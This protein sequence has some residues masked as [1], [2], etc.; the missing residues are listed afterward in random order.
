MCVSP[1]W[2]PRPAELHLADH[3]VHVWR[4]FLA[5][6]YVQA[7]HLDA[8]LSDDER[9][10][11][12]RFLSP[13]ERDRFISARGILRSLLGQYLQCP[14]AAVQ[15]TYETAGK[16]RLRTLDRDPAIRFNVTHS[17]DL[18]AYAFTRNREV[19]VDVEAVRSDG[20]LDELAERFFSPY[21][22][23][24]LRSLP[25]EVHNEAIVLC[26]TRKEAYVKARGSALGILLDSF[27]V[28]L[29]PGK[30]ERLVSD[31]SHRWMLR[32]FFPADGYVGA[33]VVEGWDSVLHLLN[34]ASFCE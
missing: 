19:G 14:A 12:S 16:P 25:P 10:R 29:T 30:P 8:V 31:D 7:R 4:A 1:K 23:A 22:L 20:S 24:E 13:Q 26:W 32:S 18:A 5:D 15:F 2:S 9:A 17:G 6:E 3:D 34:W 27:H 33:V 28:S 21:E 11:A